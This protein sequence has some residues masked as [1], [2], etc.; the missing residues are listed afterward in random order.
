MRQWR[1]RLGN[2]FFQ[3]ENEILLPFLAVGI[4]VLGGFGV[5]SFYNGY[6]IEKRGLESTARQVFSVMNQDLDFL[7]E[8]V[9]E[10]EIR[11]KYRENQPEYLRI[12]DRT[13]DHRLPQR[14]S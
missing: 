11:E 5:I 7:A 6:T 12:T 8:H 9:P 2:W 1:N 10:E 14:T 4:I 3:L 13:A